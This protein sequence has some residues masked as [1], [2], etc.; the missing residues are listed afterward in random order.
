MGSPKRIKCTLLI[1]FSDT[2]GKKIKYGLLRKKLTSH[3]DNWT[4]M[5][6]NLHLY[7]K[8]GRKEE[9]DLDGIRS[10]IA[11]VQ[12]GATAHIMLSDTINTTSL[13]ITYRASSD[14]EN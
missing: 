14:S 11:Q 6:P 12:G 7:K 5:M 10:I 3:K 4:R 1:R 8:P 2:K 13:R 9:V